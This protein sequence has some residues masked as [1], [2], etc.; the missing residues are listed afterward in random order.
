MLA[1]SVDV[2][3]GTYTKLRFDVTGIV[4]VKL[5]ANSNVIQQEYPKLPS[6]KIDMLAQDGFIV[7]PG[8]D[9]IIRLDM[10]TAESIK[11]H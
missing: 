6:E 1:L 5:D 7:G 4:M 10:S 2:P 9:L 8:S 3:T 11:Y